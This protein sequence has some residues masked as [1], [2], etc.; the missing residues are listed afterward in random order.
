MLHKQQLE[1][2]TII[3]LKPIKL[4]IITIIIQWDVPTV[5]VASTVRRTFVGGS[6]PDD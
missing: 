1:K 5:A 2:K 4:S 3:Y 6:F